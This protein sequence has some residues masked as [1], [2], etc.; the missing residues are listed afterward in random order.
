MKDLPV[1]ALLLLLYRP[2]LR[3]DR[4]LTLQIPAHRSRINIEEKAKVLAA[5]WRTDFI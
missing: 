5:V 2:K 1:E 4:V 3:K